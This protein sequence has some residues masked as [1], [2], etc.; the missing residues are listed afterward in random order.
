MKQVNEDSLR[1]LTVV[2]FIFESICNTEAVST[3]TS[4][5]IRSE[6]RILFKSDD[7]GTQR[8]PNVNVISIPFHI[9]GLQ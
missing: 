1:G 3:V 2:E 7:S 6:N 9:H 4:K 5:K 8:F